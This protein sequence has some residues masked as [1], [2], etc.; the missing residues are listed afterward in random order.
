MPLNTYQDADPN[1]AIFVN[2]LKNAN[3]KLTKKGSVFFNIRIRDPG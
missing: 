2:V 3:K 1:T